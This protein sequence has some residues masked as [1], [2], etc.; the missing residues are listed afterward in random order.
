MGGDS[1]NRDLVNSIVRSGS[2]MAAITRR[3]LFYTP[4]NNLGVL[5]CARNVKQ[6]M[7]NSGEMTIYHA[8]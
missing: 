8:R 6:S 1:K 7:E 3:T 5:V 4:I 2:E